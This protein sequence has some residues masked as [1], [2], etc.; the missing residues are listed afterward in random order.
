MNIEHKCVSS[1]KKHLVCITCFTCYLCRVKNDKAIY[2][3]LCMTYVHEK[4]STV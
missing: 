2:T 4:R 3:Q 1:E